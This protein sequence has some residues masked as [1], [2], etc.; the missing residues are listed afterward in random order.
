VQRP[1]ALRVK[2]AA[3]RIGAVA[4]IAALS[5]L[6]GLIAWRIRRED[7][8]P[9]FFRQQRAGLDG[10]P[11]ELWK[12]RS[13]VVGAD[14]IGL[15]LNVAS[16]DDRITRTGRVLRDWSL[17]ELPQLINVVRGEM[18]LVGPRPGLPDQAAR[19]DAVQRRRLA[20]RPGLTGW[21]QVNGR[22]RLS[23]EERI[24]L[25]VWYVEHWSL[26]LDVQ[27]LARTLGVVARQDGLFG[28]GGV[29]ADLGGE[30]G[31]KPPAPV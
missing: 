17:D 11:F 24:V 29:N 28:E 27:I 7:G 9:V 21:A 6:I 18:S 2:H 22:N 14:R 19:Y 3:D 10:R 16:G 8:G 12:F 23:W 4:A 25:D 26:K 1:A 31:A 13:M 20:M 30:T 5:P 15:G